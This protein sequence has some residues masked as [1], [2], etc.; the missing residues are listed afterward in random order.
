M[1]Y[2]H[3]AFDDI[4]EAIGE[5]QH[6]C[7]PVQEEFKPAAKAAN[8][9]F[10]QTSAIR[11]HASEL[12]A[13]NIDARRATVEMPDICAISAIERHAVEAMTRYSAINTIVAQAHSAVEAYEQLRSAIYDNSAISSLRQAMP[14]L[15]DKM[16]LNS[17]LG[18]DLDEGLSSYGLV[19]NGLELGVVGNI[20]IGMPAWLAAGTT[21]LDIRQA[22]GAGDWSHISAAVVAQAHS[23]LSSFEHLLNVSGLGESAARYAVHDA[24]SAAEGF[25]GQGTDNEA[26]ESS[27]TETDAEVTEVASPSTDVESEPIASCALNTAGRMWKLSERLQRMACALTFET[28]QPLSTDDMLRDVAPH[29]VIVM[30]HSPPRY[31]PELSVLFARAWSSYAMLSAPLGSSVAGHER[32]TRM[33]YDRLEDVFQGME[34]LLDEIERSC[35]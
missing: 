34:R 23:A 13:S 31:A 11:Q 24:L 4:L 20:D 30:A 35:G 5:H 22:I 2:G 6:L 18:L 29:I 27:E 7:D 21:A 26:E 25:S 14:E 15:S 10:E 28:A 32:L 9:Y 17:V 8:A 19:G 12:A 3:T 1:P 16:A 33:D